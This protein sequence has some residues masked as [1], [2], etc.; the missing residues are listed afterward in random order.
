MPSHVPREDIACL[1][2]LA[3]LFIGTLSMMFIEPFHYVKWIEVPNVLLIVKEVQSNTTM[4]PGLAAM[5][6]E[7]LYNV[8]SETV[9]PL[10]HMPADLWPNATKPMSSAETMD[11]HIF[12]PTAMLLMSLVGVGLGT[13]ITSAP[14]ALCGLFP[15]KKNTH[16]LLIEAPTEKKESV[17]ELVINRLCVA[18]CLAHLTLT[19]KIA[20]ACAMS[21]TLSSSFGFPYEGYA[22]ILAAG[23]MW[24]LAQALAMRF[25]LPNKRF[26][27]GTF[28]RSFMTTCA[29]MISLGFDTV[30]DGM[31]AGIAYSGPTAFS[32]AIGMVAFAWLWGLHIYML[33]DDELRLELWTA[34]VNVLEA[35]PVKSSDNDGNLAVEQAIKGCAASLAINVFKQTTPE[36]RKALM[37]E[38]GPQGALAVLYSATQGF[39]AVVLLLNVIVP[40]VRYVAAWLLYPWL[41][42]TSAVGSWLVEEGAVADAVWTRRP[43]T[44][45]CISVF[46]HSG[47]FLRSIQMSRSLDALKKWLK[48][49]MLVHVLSKSFA[50]K[51]KSRSL[52]RH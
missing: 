27:L 46:R 41:R 32:V 10:L 13:V 21:S 19:T 28:A 52:R 9:S 36:K 45:K 7:L 38:D 3:A 11:R 23:L 39:H 17:D 4:V 5:E 40:L 15:W 2:L 16:D 47:S 37:M 30:K 14:D 26:G 42:N 35:N 43:V 31:F 49:A 18:S 50:V 20:L 34:Y 6:K 25:M 29:P 24:L 1:S 51:A 44:S 22:V 8:S 12:W 33:R 48:Y